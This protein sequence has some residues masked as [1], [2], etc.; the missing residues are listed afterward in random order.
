M[1]AATTMADARSSA[2]T[3]TESILAE[4]LAGVMGVDSVPADSN[5]FQEL[6]ADSLVMA[7]FCARL[8]K[9]GDL[10]SVSMK[11]VYAHPTIRSLAAALA[12]VVPAAAK[13]PTAAALEQPTPTSA[14][15]HLLC[16][17]LQ[18]LFYL[19]Y[20]Y[21]GV[22]AAIEGY[23][24]LVADAVGVEKVLRL[25]LFGSVAFLIVSVLPIAVKWL[26]IG[27]WKPQQIRLWSL[28]Y[29]RFWVV[30]SLIW[31]NPGIYLCV[32]SP[33][34]NHYLRV[35]GAKIGPGVVILSRHIPVCTDLLTIGAGT[36]IR[37][38]AMFLGYRAQAGR[39][40]IGPVTLGRNAFVGEMAVLDI[41]TAMGDG[42]QLGYASSLHSGQSVPAGERWHGSPAQRTETNYVRV[43]P[44]RC[45]RLRRTVYAV[46]ALLGIFFVLAPLLEGGLGLLFLAVAS[47]VETLV[48]GLQTRAGTLTMQGLLVESL[49]FSV[50]LFFGA[51]LVGL[52]VVGTV[53]RVLNLFI[54]PDTVYPLY[55]FHYAVHRVIAGLGRLRFFPVLF[56]DSSYI[57]HFLSWI[58]YHLSPVVQ[59]GSNF[60]SEVITT[61]PLLTSVGSGTMVADGLYLINDEVSSTSFR[62]SRTAIGPRNFIGN[63]VTYPAGGRTGE[64]CLL[65]IKVMVPLDG[66]V[67]EGVGLLGSPPFEIPRSVERDSR[68]DHLRT[69]EALRRGLAAKNR[70]NLRTIGIFLCTRWL[71]VFLIVLIDLA[72]VTLFYDV[73]A[74]VIMA[75]LFALSAVVA[76]IYYALVERAFEALGPP[77]PPICSIYDPGF[78][79]VERNWKLHPINFLHIFD[80]T[81]FKSLLWR[82]IGV[83]MGKR[84]FDDGT[85]ISEPVL[86]TV[87]DECVLNHRSKIQCDSQEDGT[88]KSG[89]T[90]L[91]AG[92]TLGVGAFVHYGVT[93][94]DGSALAADSFLMK[95]ETVPPGA[96]WGGNPAREI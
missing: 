89:Y 65:A 45:G 75:M 59:T 64:N 1:K 19:G 35:L 32:G 85:H 37:R 62:V 73:F 15:E 74:H 72:A 83:R 77:P 11:D 34:Y 8:R 63:Y 69:G 94:G 50:I 41:D 76:A 71:G 60:G 30:K 33:L 10:P 9:R 84:V 39:I 57:V 2:A 49:V 40:E 90:E 23:Q 43:A 52:L 70:F 46:S 47:V 91:G 51:L 7:H 3:S 29:V 54:K 24:W 86:T 25:A 17:A 48:P 44:A 18:A 95:G 67:R 96:R 92:C 27:R 22:L 31:S 78:W 53:P 68:F 81:P 6:G 16:G 38:D 12:D 55:G 58:G 79:W 28:G 82:L 61:N 5:F 14:H 66:K 87:G 20:S 93:M 88:Y 36:V 26:L 56:G 13:P 42:A 4:V 21:L 80:G